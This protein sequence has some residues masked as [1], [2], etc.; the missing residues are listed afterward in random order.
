MGTP[1]NL[2]AALD[3]PS[4]IVMLLATLVMVAF[5]GF[6]G[7][8]AY[9]NERHGQE[10]RKQLLASELEAARNGTSAGNP[11]HSA[12]DNSTSTPGAKPDRDSS[13]PE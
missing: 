8:W 4:P 1:A 9:N 12:G 5:I 11:A 2:I 13:S 10:L 3:Y 7:Y 6:G